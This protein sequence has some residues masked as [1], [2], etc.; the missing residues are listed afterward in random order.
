ML[1]GRIEL[2]P[3]IFSGKMGGGCLEISLFAPFDL[4]KFQTKQG[5]CFVCQDKVV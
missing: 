2:T 3:F 5:A 1:F 4:I